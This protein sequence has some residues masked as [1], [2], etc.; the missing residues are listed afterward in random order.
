ML[1][2]SKKF[3]YGHNHR[4]KGGKRKDLNDLFVRSGWE[5]NY[6]RYLNWL[7]AQGAIQGWLYEPETF[8]FENVRKGTRF[9]TPDFKVF[10]NDGTFEFH[11]IKGYMDQKSRTK[12]KRMRKYYPLI[13]LVVIDSVAYKGIAKTMKSIVPNW[14]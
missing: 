3:A 10:N 7:V 11:E 13:R 8:E 4:A 5:A 2:H 6:A 9:Y 12:I 1:A 14:E